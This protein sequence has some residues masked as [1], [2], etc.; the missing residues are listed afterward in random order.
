MMAVQAHALEEADGAESAGDAVPNI[1]MRPARCSA[2][3]PPCPERAPSRCGS[4]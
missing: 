4:S 2:G 3:M 1:A